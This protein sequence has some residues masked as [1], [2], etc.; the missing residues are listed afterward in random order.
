LPP[1]EIMPAPFAGAAV[2]KAKA[3][4]KRLALARLIDGI[5]AKAMR[6]VDGLY[7]EPTLPNGDKNPAYNPDANMP[8]VEATTKTRVAVEVYRQTMQARREELSSAREL[9]VLLIRE[10]MKEADWERHAA[11]VDEAGRPK[12]VIDVVA[13]AKK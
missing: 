2:K 5:T 10:R 8:Y 11:E 7:Q 3:E 9:G 13:E 12:T 6:T 1:R 4:K